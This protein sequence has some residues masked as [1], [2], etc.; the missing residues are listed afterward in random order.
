MKQRTVLHITEA[1]GGGVRSAIVNYIEACPDFRHIVVARERPGQET[2]DWPPNTDSIIIEG[3]LLK[4]V[5]YSLR[6]LT[7]YSPDIVHLHSSH[8]GVLRGLIKQRVAI[9][10]SP[11]CFGMERRDISYI[12]RWAIRTVESVL[13]KARKQVLAAV[14]P[15][16][17]RL[18]AELAP[19]A[20]ITIVPNPAP[21]MFSS[22][23]VVERS[24]TVVAVGRI[25]AQKDPD[26]FAQ[27][28]R[29][30]RKLN[31][32]F[33]WIGSG[34]PD[35]TTRLRESGV[36]VTG[37]IQP[38]EALKIL[39]ECSLYVH[40][41]QWEGA[42]ISSI[43][44]AS[45]GLP[46]L[47]RAIPSMVSLG[48]ATFGESDAELATAMK[49]FFQ[50]ENYKNQVLSQTGEVAHHN[51]FDQMSS[52]LRLAYS[53]AID[54]AAENARVTAR[55]RRGCTVHE[56]LPRVLKNGSRQ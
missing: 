54:L 6:K 30:N 10:Y 31:L 7:K 19:R 18:A 8:A 33:V 39:A 53:K 51:S 27:A 15:Y 21:K 28:A 42:P 48:Y 11:H 38:S 5:L 55:L 37:W 56:S 25:C 4:F 52:A 34:D 1:L 29:A 22:V 47:A 20:A 16:E 24:D 3:S 14:S 49:L 43:E 13:L 45:L 44:A 40:T 46:V 23:G 50:D 32:K 36:H 12:N 35:A 9:V 17:A 41:A 26:L 2:Y